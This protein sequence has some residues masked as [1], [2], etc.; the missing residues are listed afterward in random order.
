MIYIFNSKIFSKK[1]W[2]LT[3]GHPI[4]SGIELPIV[5]QEAL[6]RLLAKV[7]GLL[8]SQPLLGRRDLLFRHPL[9]RVR[10]LKDLKAIQFFKMTNKV[11]K[12]HLKFIKSILIHIYVI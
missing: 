1:T 10:H 9:H 4:C 5:H 3:V 12:V 6:R 2:V 11:N 8:P 7:L